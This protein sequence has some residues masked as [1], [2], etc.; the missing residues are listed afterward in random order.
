MDIVLSVDALTPNPGGIGRYTWE[1]CKGLA[2]RA[3]IDSL[4]YAARGR[5]I[6]DPEA[7]LRGARPARPRGPFRLVAERKLRQ[8]FRAS[9][10][11]GPNYFLPPLAVTGVI[12]VHDLSVLRFPETHPA[13]RV[14]IFEKQLIPSIERSLQIITDAEAIRR[15]LIDTFSLAPD[16][17]TAIPLGVEQRFRPATPELAAKVREQWGLTAGAYG[18]CVTTLEPR[19][20]IP[21]LIR[22]WRN[23]PGELR[24]RFPLVLAGGSGWRNESILEEVERA[25]AEGWLLNLGFVDDARL[26]GLYAGAALFA[27]P[28][29]YEGFG[30]PPLE[31]MASGVPVIVARESSLPEVCGDAARYVCPDDVD[32]FA[33]AI[34]EILGDAA[35]R[36]GMVER[37]LARAREFTWERCTEA[38]VDVYRAALAA[39]GA[40]IP[41]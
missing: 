22:A 40:T 4:R 25:A 26:P 13:E 30:L 10:V 19:K 34:R 31:A 5:L 12:T 38:T 11:H 18:L 36:A 7:L 35:L 9:L 6:D 16:K 15:E 17:V 1:L 21:E 28:S 32:E 41:D 3:D 8:A 29:I 23:L 2:R 27:Y 37:G 33:E 24:A 20:R 39:S 14:K